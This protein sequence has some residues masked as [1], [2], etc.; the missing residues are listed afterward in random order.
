MRIS[1]N[2]EI[3]EL[4][5]A[6]S[7]QDLIA[8]LKLGDRRVAVERNGEILPRSLYTQ[9]TLIDGDRLEIVHAIGGG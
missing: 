5:P 9:T 1:V 8:A 3:R 4:P 2:N 6:S 7:V